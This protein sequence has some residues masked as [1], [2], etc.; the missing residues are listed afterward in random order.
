[1]LGPPPR[2]T[3]RRRLTRAAAD[4]VRTPVVGMRPQLRRSSLNVC[5][6]VSSQLNSIRQADFSTL[7][8]SFGP[9]SPLFEDGSYLTLLHLGEGAERALDGV[10]SALRDRTAPSS[11]NSFMCDGG[12]RPHLVGAIACLLDRQGKLDRLQLW[13]AAD[14]GSWVSPQLVV[15][16]LYS[17]AEFV[18][19]ARQRLDSRG[20]VRSPAP[21]AAQRSTVAEIPESHWIRRQLARLAP[22]LL[23]GPAYELNSLMRHVVEGPGADSV[24]S[25]KL[26]ASLLA[27]CHRV[28]AL[29]LSEAA[30]REEP[31]VKQ[32]LAQ[33]VDHS[34]KLAL[35]WMS[36]AEALFLKRGLPLQQQSA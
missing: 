2:I 29:A 36:A 19:R 11:F 7:P 14:A 33:D 10:A 17:D 15:A 6:G 32:L 9:F 5:A 21:P 23:G 26:T 25:A 22:R 24:R 31:E 28:P 8:T 34:E 18:S 13:N 12:W 35:S 3:R 4:E 1:M 16:A 27:V 20:Q 30:W